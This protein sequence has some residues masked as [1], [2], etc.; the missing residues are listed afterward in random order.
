M[1]ATTLQFSPPWIIS[2]KIE[3]RLKGVLGVSQ[4]FSKDSGLNAIHFSELLWR[5]W[6]T[7]HGWAS[8]IV[9]HACKDSHGGYY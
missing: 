2:E 3:G 4:R 9:S 8:L 1:E 7:R 5:N 6:L